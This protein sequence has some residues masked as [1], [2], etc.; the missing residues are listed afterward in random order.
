[1]KIGFF[2]DVHAN[3]FGLN[4][5]ID[6]LRNEI[7]CGELFFLGDSVGYFSEPN[8]VIDRL[9][10]EKIQ[11]LLGNHDAMA[12]GRI[13]Y[14]KTADEMYKMTETLGR[15]S[16]ENLDFLNTLSPQLTIERAGATALLAHGSPFSPLQEYVYPDSDLTGYESLGFDAIFLGHT[17]R[18]FLSI[19][20]RTMVVNVG[21]CGLPREQ[22]H[23]LSAAV[24]DTDSRSVDL[25]RFDWPRDEA[26]AYFSGKTHPR[27]LE[28][29]FRQ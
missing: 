16:P 8:L 14:S 9:R 6:F 12:L 5:T 17:H 28:C 1:V 15:I 13:E 25:L 26:V 20:G 7:G 3:P 27:V 2:S 22:S 21:S 24:W 11:C 10:H 29:L 18:P 23:K 4:R 19:Q